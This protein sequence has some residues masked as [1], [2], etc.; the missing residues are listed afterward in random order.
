MVSMT[1]ANVA[2]STGVTR[3]SLGTNSTVTARPPGT[4]A[5][6]AL[7]N[8]ASQVGG[9]KR[10]RKFGRSTRA[11]SRPPSPLRAEPGPALAHGGRD[12]GERLPDH[13][14]GEERDRRPEVGRRAAI[15]ERAQHGVERVAAIVL[16]EE[17]ERRE[18]V[19]QDAYAA[20]GGLAPCR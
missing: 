1:R 3:F 7:R 12:V 15:E 17:T 18:R 4:S 6:C 16:V 19:A 10:W 5:A 9:S 13:R 8:T 14:G 11:E 2:A 20:L